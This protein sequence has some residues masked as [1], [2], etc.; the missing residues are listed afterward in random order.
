[1]GFVADFFLLPIESWLSIISYSILMIGVCLW[2]IN[3][4]T[5]AFYDLD[6]DTLAFF[7]ALTDFDLG[8]VNGFLDLDKLLLLFILDCF[9]P[10]DTF[11]LLFLIFFDL[12]LTTFKVFALFALVVTYFKWDLNF[13][14][15]GFFALLVTFF[16][17]AD[18]TFA[19]L[20]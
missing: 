5:D 18:I 9:L 16:F 6:F 15:L 20:F 1:L 10:F 8:F 19:I 4:V 3:G 2:L 17:D 12:L 14:L 11:N 7:G 13:P